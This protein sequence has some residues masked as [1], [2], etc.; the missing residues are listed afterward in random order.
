MQLLHAEGEGEGV[1][2]VARATR[3]WVEVLRSIPPSMVRS[4]GLPG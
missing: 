2:Y 1:V 4:C 3:T